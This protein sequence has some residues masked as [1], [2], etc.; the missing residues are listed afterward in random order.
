MI[1]I[2][3][4]GI[5]GKTGNTLFNLAKTNDGFNVVFGV[6]A[7]NKTK[8]GTPVFDCF[9]KAEKLIEKRCSVIK[10]D[11]ATID[12]IIDFSSPSALNGILNFAEK[13]SSAVVLATTG[14][15]SDDLKTINRFGEKIPVF[16]S[17]NLSLGVYALISACK[18]ICDNL[19]DFD[20]EIIEK[21]HKRK[22]D[23][24][25]GTALKIA[26]EILPNIKHEKFCGSYDKNLS[27]LNEKTNDIPLHSV[28]GGE[29][30]GEHE[31]LF[32]TN[33]EIICIKHTALNRELFARSALDIAKFTVN[34]PCGVYGMEDYAKFSRKNR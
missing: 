28:R 11:G 27:C 5:L 12:A 4:C 13:H 8:N 22:K 31:V 17:Q 20:I 9:E 33:D 30:F 3:I 24:P 14:Y 34:M 19:P 29:I 26:T 6:D 32:M 16:Y 10:K 2:A 15:T 21:H 1:N 23:A 25:S 18:S 7:I